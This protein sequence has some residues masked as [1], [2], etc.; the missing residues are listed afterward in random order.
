MYVAG[1]LIIQY[2]CI[3]S[4]RSLIRTSKSDIKHLHDQEENQS[5]AELLRL[6]LPLQCLC[7]DFV[8]II[9]ICLLWSVYSFLPQMWGLCLLE[10]HPQSHSFGIGNEW[11]HLCL[12]KRKYENCFFFFFLKRL[13][14][15]DS[16]A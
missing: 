8:F 7:M 9:F 6:L 12:C 3:L 10:V 1:E 15:G 16:C 5:T 4:H 2:I 13:N 14:V 11:M